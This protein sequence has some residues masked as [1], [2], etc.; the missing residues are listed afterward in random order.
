MTADLH[1]ILDRYIE[2][3][4]RFLRA[5]TEE[6]ASAS[7]ALLTECRAAISAHVDALTDEQII[8]A[9]HADCD[10]EGD[11]PMPVD[12]AYLA[13]HC[14]SVRALARTGNIS[15]LRILASMGEG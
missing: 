4:P 3:A 1:T 9:T 7:A 2:S 8:T 14:A 15:D 13:A 11:G 12:A 6:Q 10:P 5:M